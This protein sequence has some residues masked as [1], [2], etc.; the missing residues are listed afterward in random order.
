[1]T[2]ERF[3]GELPAHGVEPIGIAL[4]GGGVRAACLGLGALQRF[5]ERELLHRTRYVAA[6]S[7]GSYI[8][9]AFLASRALVSNGDER[10]D[11]N[12]L[13]WTRGSA[14]E[15]WLKRNLRYLAEDRN[16]LL[17]ALGLYIRGTV[18]NLMAFGAA[19]VA[20]GCALG[21]VL[22]QSFLIRESTGLAPK[23]GIVRLCLAGA[24]LL[25]IAGYESATA[26]GQRSQ[27]AKWASTLLAFSLAVLVLPNLVGALVVVRDR[28]VSYLGGFGKGA[29]A[30]IA[31]Y[32]ATRLRCARDQACERQRSAGCSQRSHN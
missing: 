22:R 6:V 24:L 31:T 19:I 1:M 9:T 3:L 7:G 27:H 18:L 4:S 23:H 8:A 30:L 15:D 10:L 16:D 12:D 26:R 28:Q 29:L 11:P 5:E 20:T 32:I 21:L 2:N 17:V 14:E 13:P 25:V